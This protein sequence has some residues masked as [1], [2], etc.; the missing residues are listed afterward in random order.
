[1]TSDTRPQ[2]IPRSPAPRA[3]SQ[4]QSAL[5]TLLCL[6]VLCVACLGGETP[7]APFRWRKVAGVENAERV[8]PSAVDP[9]TVFVWTRGGLFVS[10][11][12]GLTFTPRGK[13]LVAQLGALTALVVSPV[14]PATLYAGTLDKGVFLSADEGA[15]WRALGGVEQGL[16]GLR[17]HALVFSADDPTF[18]TLYATHSPRQPGISLTIDGGRTWRSFAL[19][20]GAGDLILRGVTMFFAGA[21]P[22]GG[23]Q[24]GFY[25]SI[26]AG[27]NWFRIL[28]VEAPTVL[29][30]SRV[31][32]RRAWC[33]T[34]A[35]L[36]VTDD[37]G[38]STRAA[39]PRTGM[40]VASIAAGYGPGGGE[41]VYVYDPN[42]EGV[43]ATTDGFKTWQQLNDGLYVGDWVAEGAM[44]A[45]AGPTLFACVNGSLY[46]GAP[47][48]GPAQ[49]S[50][51]RVAPAA[52]VAGADAVTFTCRA[53]PGAAVSIDLSPL[54]AAA[55][56]PMRDDG[57]SG[58]GAAD[59][60]VFG[61]R[62]EKIPVEIL[63]KSREPQYQGPRL[64]GALGLAV[65]A[66]AGA[67]AETGFAVLT[68]LQP[69]ANVT[70]WN[71][72][73]RNGWV[74]RAE[75]GV[76]LA[77]CQEHPFSGATHLRL[78]VSGPGLAGFGWKKRGGWP[79]GDDTRF[80]KLFT[81]CIRSDSEGPSGL[82]L[83]LRDDGG[84]YGGENAQ[85]SNLL[86][87]A[88]Y[89]PRLTP[90][91]QRVAIPLADFILGA[92]AAPDRIRELVFVAPEAEA[93]AYDID[94]LGLAVKPGPLLSAC[95]AAPSADGL[96]LRL[97]ACVTSAAGRPRSVK[98]CG[99]DREFP[100]YDDGQHGDGESG[101]ACYAV[102]VPVA[103]AGSGTRSFRFLAEDN[104]GAT[105]ETLAAFVPRRA[106]G[107]IARAKGSISL[108]A[109]L[110]E[111]ADVAPFVA[112]GGSL[113]LRAR[114]LYDK[115]S[116]YAAVEVKDAAFTPWAPAKKGEKKPSLE[117]LAERGSVELAITS[118]A[119]A[120][121]QARSGLAEADQRFV[122]V[123]DEKEGFALRA[124]HR[125]P[126]RGARTDSGYLIEAQIPFDQLRTRK[127]QCDFQA[128]R[129][130]RVEWRLLGADGTKLAWAAPNAEAS[131]DP[132]NWGLARFTDEAGAPR[133][134]YTRSDGKVVTLLSNKRLKAAAARNLSAYDVSGARLEKAGL[135]KDCRT[136]RL[137][138]A[139]PWQVG[140]T[141][142]IKFRGV[143]SEDGFPAEP[144][145]A[146]A[147]LPGRPL[148]G[149][150]LQELLVGE[151]RQNVALQSVQSAQLD[152][153]VRPVCGPQWRHAEVESGLFD[154]GELVGGLNNALVHAHAYVFSDAARAVQVWVG[155]DDGARVVVNGAP[156]F[157]VPATRGCSPDQDKIKGVKLKQGWNS[158]LLAVWNGGG[159]WQGCVR[160]M[161]EDGNP[162]R[163]VSYSAD[164]PSADA[165]APGKE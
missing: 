35:G 88:R 43:L 129:S 159:V 93:R 84:H 6:S 41:L 54:G 40:N 53:A 60:G 44:L 59:D 135:E 85:P 61:A 97:S 67:A 100:L 38:V 49:L 19:D 20:F 3:K 73:A 13:D 137:T 101:D 58:D 31:S 64:P 10:Q 94:D 82:R 156:V 33:G 22:A 146:F 99:A 144:E 12:S 78:R 136:L 132:E 138:A 126:A 109:K 9:N 95:E 24:M 34:Q 155:S 165:A 115:N 124:N 104:E 11:D 102:L 91:Y 123:M 29:V 152:E 143:E 4:Q 81:F 118:P 25:R 154:F 80:H 96:S 74:L 42:T 14:C 103:Q 36:F 98:A 125:L 62:L 127:E 83:M 130:T 110:D 1:M 17:I 116:L 128:G 30:G 28:N 141:V 107:Q 75:G 111:F 56:T 164:S 52:A 27:R 50:S 161:D 106:P 32:P 119:S 162:P 153:N 131:A 68:V 112:G 122:F 37:F 71:G 65:R 39:G 15:A 2:P 72:E 23:P 92:Q 89:L 114:L 149:E 5:R 121:V 16:A 113:E 157:S 70:L 8:F 158:L 145:L 147:P 151:V 7:A 76:G 117:K 160:I 105:E 45:A 18:T 48:P 86:P 69:A 139:A 142:T 66:G 148:N 47:P 133:L 26:D 55:G 87:L 163:G 150:L 90:A 63:A 108:D 77:A 46:R 120:A 134:R 51:V 140:R 79:E 21:R 57:R